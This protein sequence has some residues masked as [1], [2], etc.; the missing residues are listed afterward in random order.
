MKITTVGDPE[1]KLA[2]R[3]SQLDRARRIAVLQEKTHSRKP[4]QRRRVK[5]ERDRRNKLTSIEKWRRRSILFPR[6]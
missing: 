4:S 3:V 6:K 5:A 2:G 1:M